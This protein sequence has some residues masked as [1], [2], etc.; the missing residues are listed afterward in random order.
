MNCSLTEMTEQQLEILLN[1]WN[2]MNM[3]LSHSLAMLDDIQNVRDQDHTRIM[4]T[5]Y[6][7][8]GWISEMLESNKPKIE[9]NYDTALDT[10]NIYET[11]VQELLDEI[12]VI[13]DI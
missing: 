8:Q 10:M 13:Y 11:Q 3:S 6:Y 12:L 9:Q 7:Q 1:L 4:A 2:L 5:L